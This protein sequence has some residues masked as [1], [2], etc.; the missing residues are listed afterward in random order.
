MGGF[1]YEDLLPK[2][3]ERMIDGV[4]TAAMR[5][6]RTRGPVEGRAVRGGGVAG[7]SRRPTEAA[8]ASLLARDLTVWRRRY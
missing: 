4:A 6:H 3:G 2:S 5:R 7:G 1:A 8:L